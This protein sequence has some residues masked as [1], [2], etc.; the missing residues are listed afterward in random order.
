MLGA[1]LVIQSRPYR[2]RREL[3]TA[4]AVRRP[5]LSGAKA[6]RK[7]PST[8]SADPVRE[9]GSRIG[10]LTVEN[11][12]AADGDQSTARC[13]SPQCRNLKRGVGIVLDGQRR[14]GRAPRSGLGR[15][16]SLDLYPREMEVFAEF[17][18]KLN[19][20]AGFELPG[21][22]GDPIE[23]REF[24]SFYYDTDDLSLSRARI[25]LRRRVE[26]DTST[27]QLKL[28]RADDRLELSANGSGDRPPAELARL[29]LAHTRHGKLTEVAEL[30][31]RRKGELV[32]T[33]RMS[34]EVTVDQVTVID[35]EEVRNEFV[36]IEV[37]LKTGDRKGVER[38]V[39]KLERAG[40]SRANGLPKLFR[41]L[42]LK[43]GS[44]QR[45][46]SEANPVA[47]LR[48]SLEQQ[49]V[50]IL[51]HDPG[52]RLGADLD[53]LHDMRV[54]VRRTRA[55][56]RAG[57]KLIAT[58]TNELET[59]LQWI[60]EAL[61]AVRDLDVMLAQLQREV[62]ALDPRDRRAA[63][64]LLRH[65][66]RE[67]TAAQR[68]LLVALESERYLLL[69]DRY[70]T[71]VSRL[72]PATD[73]PSLDSLA[74]NELAKLRRFVRGLDDRPADG[75]LHLLRKRDKRARY[76]AELAGHDTVVKRATK[77]QE[78]LGQHQDAVVAGDRLRALAA[79]MSPAQALATGRL[80]EREQARKARA[81][82]DWPKAWRRLRR[83]R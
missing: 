43:G 4:T 10:S 45:G 16:L 83:S 82:S 36:E 47:T 14:A 58:D 57:R 63:R 81:R 60:G 65:L 49:L 73:A 80:V 21:L 69:L 68:A 6:D 77:L 61:G 5:N 2:W 31:T 25:T 1:S 12:L 64:A 34:A 62:R 17:E 67:R 71:T 23:P 48:T 13:A 18:R 28:P 46:V 30:H 33:D 79:G 54:A 53:S 22:E 66:R 55:L 38:I 15:P 24:T 44:D 8:V 78:I 9:T 76:T 26:G 50:E 29:L 27:W 11:E 39:R 40:A 20:P 41:A 52:T 7:G 19:A 42:E 35:A 32:R 56:L 74:R 75:E 51:A 72:E 70:E 3:C 37:E 59:D